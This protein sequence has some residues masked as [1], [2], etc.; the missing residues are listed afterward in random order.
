MEYKEGKLYLSVK[1]SPKSSS[2]CLLPYTEGD[3]YLRIKIMGA[4]V[5]GQVNTRL[6]EYLSTL[7]SI[8]K[9]SIEIS[10][11]AKSKIKKLIIQ[12]ITPLKALDRLH[13]IS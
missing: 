11:G 1:V 3:S 8:P 10:S 7:L 13:N 6:I 12:T 9:G 5:K 2:N 4:P